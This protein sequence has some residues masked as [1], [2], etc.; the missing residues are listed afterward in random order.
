MA[1][2][3]A[4]L[5]DQNVLLDTTGY[6]VTNGY[7]QTLGLTQRSFTINPA[8]RTLV[9]LVPGQSWGADVVTTLY[10]PVN[11]A[12]IDNFNIYDGN[13][14]A[15]GG[16][17]LGTTYQAT[18]PL[19][20]GNAYAR[21][22]D[23]LVTNGKFDRVI[24]VP[25]S[26]GG[27]TIAQWGDVNAPYSNRAPVALRRLAARGITPATP[28]VTFTCI[29]QIGITDFDN[30]TS[31]ASFTASALSF[32]ATLQA[33]GFIG[34]IFVA[35]QSRV[36][37]VANAIRSAQ[38]SLWNGTTIFSGGDNDSNTITLSDG[39]HPDDAGAATLSVIVYNAMHASGAPY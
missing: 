18:P 26:V 5:P 13:L 22:A 23:L 31:Q 37:Q 21:V 3:G 39:V 7:R 20:P 36:G 15:I 28:G 17:L 14:Y 1:F 24:M 9:M 30:G 2:T 6:G 35:L 12:V 29:L 16:P 34:R 33:S 8:L 38:A 4:S 11:T 32:L 10:T 27:T 25:I 19:G